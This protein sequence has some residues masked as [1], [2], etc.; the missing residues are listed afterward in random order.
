MQGGC[1]KI[2]QVFVE[3]VKSY[4]DLLEEYEFHPEAKCADENGNP[5]S[6]GT[7]GL[8]KRRRIRVGQI[9]FIGKESN[10]LEEV[11]SGLVH[12]A[13]NVYTEYQDSKRDEWQTNIVPAL[14][15]MFVNEASGRDR[16]VAQNAY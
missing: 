13:H 11:G 2:K 7:V 10:T 12:S 3:R 4:G 1:N 16:F 15:T 6:K 9:R 5:C 8:L 14:R